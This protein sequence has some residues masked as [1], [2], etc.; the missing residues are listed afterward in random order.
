[1]N[2]V[3]GCVSV[4]EFIKDN[5]ELIIA[6]VTFVVTTIPN[7]YMLY[8]EKK[9]SM[10]TAILLLNT[11]KVEDKMKSG[12]FSEELIKKTEEIGAI[13][14]T[15][16]KAVNNVKD[17]LNAANSTI[18]SV[19]HPKTIVPTDSDAE[20]IPDDLADAE[21]V[22]DKIKQAIEDPNNDVKLGSYK[23]RPIYLNDIAKTGQIVGGLLKLFRR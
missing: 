23:G 21:A 19:L 14:N 7:L 1:M 8:K 6:G 9:L 15:G 18:D 22:D 20:V 11:L 3:D 16:A 17:I 4:L 13:A 5:R 2:L 12:K 10:E